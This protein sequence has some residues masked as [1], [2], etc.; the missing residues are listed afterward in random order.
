MTD[1]VNYLFYKTV[2]SLNMTTLSN[3]QKTAERTGEI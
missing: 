1:L 2:N 3:S